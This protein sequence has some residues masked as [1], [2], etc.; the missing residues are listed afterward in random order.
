MPPTD[1][2]RRANMCVS[3]P[4]ASNNPTQRRAHTTTWPAPLSTP[5][6]PDRGKRTVCQNHL[7]PCLYASTRQPTSRKHVR[8]PSP[9]FQLRVNKCV[10]NFL[11]INVTLP[12]YVCHHLANERH[13]NMCMPPPGYQ[14]DSKKCA[15]LHLGINVTHTCAYA[16]TRL[17][18]PRKH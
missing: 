12:K 11:A 9:G 2:Q 17:S 5:R 1:Y 8:I 18:T 4:L 7:R 15:C 3:R 14:R 6:G 10:C 13:A 16:V